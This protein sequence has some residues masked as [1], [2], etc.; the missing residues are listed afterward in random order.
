MENKNISCTIKYDNKFIIIPSRLYLQ[1]FLLKITKEMSML[2]LIWACGNW[3]NVYLHWEIMLMLSIHLKCNHKLWFLF[4][5]I[6]MI[7]VV[8]YICFTF[9]YDYLQHSDTSQMYILFQA[10]CSNIFFK[11]SPYLDKTAESDVVFSKSLLYI[12]FRRK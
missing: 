10:L 11:I 2:S 6:C 9:I 3:D 5:G 12:C 4:H 1:H 8:F 7:C